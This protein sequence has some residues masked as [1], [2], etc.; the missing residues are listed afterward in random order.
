MSVP[1]FTAS[2]LFL[3]QQLDWSP[4]PGVDWETDFLT[5][6]AKAIELEVPIVATTLSPGRLHFVNNGGEVFGGPDW[7]K[8]SEEAVW[9]HYGSSW[10]NSETALRNRRFEYRFDITSAP[11]TQVIDPFSLRSN[12]AEFNE[13]TGLRDHVLSCVLRTGELVPLDKFKEWDA[14]AESLQKQEKRYRKGQILEFAEHPDRAVS[15]LALERM[16]RKFED[17]F[18]ELVPDLLAI[19]HGPTLI[20]TFDFLMRKDCKKENAIRSALEEW[21]MSWRKSANP[22]PLLRRAT[23]CIGK[24][25]DKGSRRCIEQALDQDKFSG[26][27]GSAAA[28]ATEQLFER[29]KLSKKEAQM[30]LAMG[31]PAL[32]E[33]A[34]I[35]VS[36][37]LMM[38]A[39]A[40]HEALSKITKKRVRFPEQYTS[41]SRLKLIDAWSP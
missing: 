4:P 10:G 41:E 18:E 7:P 3:A 9:F 26:A 5:A 39:Q 19:N 6:R 16:S 27:V 31:F 34:P 11:D 14:L 32:P 8:I 23:W 13:F 38:T 33:P 36:P 24:Y 1:L 20:L 28:E 35:E 29:R 17:E 37:D 30:L 2:V 21:F 12:E 15:Y 40:L 25:G 22:N